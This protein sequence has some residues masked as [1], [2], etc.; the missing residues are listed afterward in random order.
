MEIGR[1]NI[2]M[3]ESNRE[4]LNF[5]CEHLAECL[6]IARRASGKTAAV[7]GLMLG[8]SSGRLRAYESGKLVPSL[9]E[10]ESL[11]YIFNIPFAALFDPQI[12]SQY[13]HQPASNQLTQLIL[14]RQEII[15]TRLQLAREKS[16]R[17]LNEIAFS[18]QIS[19]SRLKKYEKGRLAIPLTELVKIAGAIGIDM[20]ELIDR[21]SQLGLW[22]A[23]QE[24]AFNFNQLPEEIRTFSLSSENQSYIAFTQRI[25]EMGVENLTRLSDSIRQILDSL[26]QD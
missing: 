26:R 12:L 20:S 15:A 6:T 16:G 19:P 13:I 25:K 7:C 1:T 18:A 23:E 17:T 14:I 3:D 10:M 22:Q 4:S 5:S 8:I 21:E 11:S 9:P 24:N 2:D